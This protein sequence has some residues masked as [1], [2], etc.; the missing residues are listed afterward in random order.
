MIDIVMVTYNRLEF[1]KKTLRAIYNRTKFPYR[2]IVIDNDSTDGTREYLEEDD[3]IDVLHFNI[4][5]IGLEKAL[6]MGLEEVKSNVFVTT[7]NDCIPPL[8]KPCWLKQLYDLFQRH[9]DYAAIALRPQILIGVGKIFNTDKEVVENN[10][11]GGSFRIMDT[12][13]VKEVGGWS[14]QFVN[15]GRGNEEWDICTKLRKAGYKVGYAKNLWTYHMFGKENWGYPKFIDAAKS[16]SIKTPFFKDI[17]YNPIT[18]E[19]KIKN[20]E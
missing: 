17:E 12:K 14:N 5:N 20:N 13:I 9:P 6:Q 19:P 10:V 15:N 4:K 3:R 8:L 7:D 16:R 2:L 18:C 11:V 1:T